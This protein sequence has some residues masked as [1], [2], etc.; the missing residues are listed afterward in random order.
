M[1]GTNGT[2]GTTFPQRLS[3]TNSLYTEERAI[4]MGLPGREVAPGGPGGPA[5]PTFGTRIHPANRPSRPDNPRACERPVTTLRGRPPA[6]PA[7]PQSPGRTSGR[8]AHPAE[9]PLWA[10]GSGSSRTSG[11]VLHGRQRRGYAPATDSG[12]SSVFGCDNRAER[13]PVRPAQSGKSVRPV[14]VGE[15]VGEKT[16]GFGL[17]PP[18]YAR[19]F[20]APH[21]ATHSLPTRSNHHAR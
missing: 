11:P 7:D 16:S 17:G 4:S 21:H 20:S 12:P 15:G 8:S 3:Q 10:R 1:N 9:S 13:E 6:G 19:S 18:L 14:G 2:T 5:D